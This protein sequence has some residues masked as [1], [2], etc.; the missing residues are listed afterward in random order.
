MT[1]RQAAR[2]LGL[3]P[4]RA[5]LGIPFFT[6][7]FLLAW[8]SS[9]SGSE[10]I[11]VTTEQGNVED[12]R[13]VDDRGPLS[14][15]AEVILA[16][17]TNLARNGSNIIVT[18]PATLGSTYRLERKLSLTDSTWQTISGVSDLTATNNGFAQITDPGAINLGQAFY[19]VTLPYQVNC[20]ALCFIERYAAGG[21]IPPSPTLG[22]RGLSSKLEKV[23]VGFIVDT[24]GSMGGSITALR[25]SLSTTIIPALQARIPNLGIGV[26]GHDDVPV[27]PYG[28]TTDLPFYVSSPPNGYVTTV[29]AQSQTAANALITHNGL[30]LPESQVPGIYKAITGAAITWP[31]GS[32]AADSPPAGTFGA[33]R[34]RSDAFPIVINITDISHHNGKRALDKT[35]TNYDGAFQNTYSFSTFNVDNVVMAMNNIGA[36][37]IGVGA[38]GGAR[39]VGP[40]DPYGYSAYITDRTDSNVSPSAF[41]PGPGCVAGQCC[42]GVSGAGVT[43]DGPGGSC[44]SVWSVSTS[45]TGLS[46]S[47][48]NGVVALLDTSRFNVYVQ[49]YNDPAETIDVVST[50]ILKVEPDPAGGID[51]VTGEACVSFPASQLADNFI[52]PKA[53][54]AGSDGVPD[55]I[56][57]INPG[58]L[59]CFKVTPKPNAVIPQTTT[60]Q[61]FRAWLRVL[62]IKPDGTIVLGPDREILFIVP[63]IGY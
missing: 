57:Q 17:P 8:I 2:I 3:R 46:T 41:T 21:G 12:S 7:L 56:M 22:V 40:N 20:H 47:I 54:V 18:F 52:G 16:R 27:S 36:K 49:A 39:G 13:S 14:P 60:E 53:L 62:A 55:T 25:N 31:G 38:D 50:F 44:R 26:A 4:I 33:L 24:T 58:P 29:T 63:P 1:M 28:A 19:R 35:G 48:V 45:G 9:V 32:L 15:D 34:F 43:P 37:F 23:D 30:D 51:P 10:S 5:A 6:G 61:A 59:Y 11:R 42:T